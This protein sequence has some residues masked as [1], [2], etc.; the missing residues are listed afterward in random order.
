MGTTEL[1]AMLG[2]FVMLAL[3]GIWK[4]GKAE[5]N[6]YRRFVEKASELNLRMTK[7]EKTCLEENS[8]VFLNALTRIEQTEIKTVAMFQRVDEVQDHCARLREQMVDLRDRSYPRKI[9]VTF[10]VKGAIP[11]EVRGPTKQTTVRPAAK[12]KIITPARAKHLLKKTTKQLK[13]LS[14]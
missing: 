7:L 12:K 4:H 11:I 10:P 14:K 2:L 1:L 6:D 8:Q 13:G 3:Y 5:D 9:E